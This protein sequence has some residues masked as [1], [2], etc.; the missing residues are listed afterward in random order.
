MVGRTAAENEEIPLA[1]LF[2]FEG[3]TP[4]EVLRSLTRSKK[5]QRM[6]AVPA[7]SERD[8]P[9]GYQGPKPRTRVR[10]NQEGL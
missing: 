10:R 5:H 1:L 3:R 8:V 2:G 9:R 4:A 6:S 7:R